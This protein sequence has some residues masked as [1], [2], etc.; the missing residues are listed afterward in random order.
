M[1]Q[2]QT[3]SERNAETFTLQFPRLRERI[4]SLHCFPALTAGD[5]GLK[6]DDCLTH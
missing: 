1:Y 4:L 5:F 3:W 6:S 2:S